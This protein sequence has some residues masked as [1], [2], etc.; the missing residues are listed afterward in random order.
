MRAVV[1]RPAVAVA[2]LGA[3][4]HGPGRSGGGG[5]GSGQGEGHSRGSGAGRLGGASELHALGGGSATVVCMQF[6]LYTLRQRRA[7]QLQ[8]LTK[9][10]GK[11]ADHEIQH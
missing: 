9:G 1:A 2:T 4:L 3:K 7:T 6:T 8:P 11:V 5:G 10:P